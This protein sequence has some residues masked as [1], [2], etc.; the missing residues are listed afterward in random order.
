MSK[1]KNSK[2]L[3]LGPATQGFLVGDNTLSKDFRDLDEKSRAYRKERDISIPYTA[4][5]SALVLEHA[6]TQSPPEVKSLLR[7]WK[8]KEAAQKSWDSWGHPEIRDLSESQKILQQLADHLITCACEEHSLSVKANVMR[9]KIHGSRDAFEFQVVEQAKT[10]VIKRIHTLTSRV[11]DILEK[12]GTG[13][14]MTVA[15]LRESS[16]AVGDGFE[17]QF[18][19]DFNETEFELA[20]CAVLMLEKLRSLEE[21]NYPRKNREELLHKLDSVIGVTELFKVKHGLV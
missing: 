13:D 21:N 6:T 3:L 19:A 5:F 10:E 15:V 11:A 8:L 7:D 12:D 18:F 20:L 16:V 4:Q 2:D 17:S 14:N 9:G 1:N